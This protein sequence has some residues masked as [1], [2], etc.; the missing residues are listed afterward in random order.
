MNSISNHVRE[1]ASGNDCDVLDTTCE[2][3]DHHAVILLLRL[4]STSVSTL[5][6]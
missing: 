4:A 2:R 1:C 5:H 6:I 3:K